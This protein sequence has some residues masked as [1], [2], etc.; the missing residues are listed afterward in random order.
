MREVGT[1]G[2][3][4]HPLLYNNRA[5]RVASYGGEGCVPAP[6]RC[7]VCNQLHL[8]VDTSCAFE[9]ARSRGSGCVSIDHTVKDLL[10]ILNDPLVAI[11]ARLVPELALARSAVPQFV[12]AKTYV[13]INDPRQF[14]LSVK[15][16]VPGQA[17]AQYFSVQS[18][19]KRMARLHNL[20]DLDSLVRQ[21]R[22]GPSV[23]SIN[24]IKKNKKASSRLNVYRLH[25]LLGKTDENAVSFV[26]FVVISRVAL[27][28]PICLVEKADLLDIVDSKYLV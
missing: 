25:S 11:P 2:C 13:A 19:Y 18:I 4:Y 22:R 5:R 24:R 23:S 12:S 27:Q 6:S 9:V 16:T 1:L 14:N 17:S 28:K 7:D 15:L 10:C 26:P 21:A 3:S 20:P 8:M